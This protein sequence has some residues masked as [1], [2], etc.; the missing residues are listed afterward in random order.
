M[1][2]C[3][4]HTIGV[5]MRDNGQNVSIFGSEAVFGGE[6]QRYEVDGHA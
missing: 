3:T 4:P 2:F 5:T 6:T 1:T